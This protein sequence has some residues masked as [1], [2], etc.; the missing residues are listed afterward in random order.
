MLPFGNQSVTCIHR[1][2]KTDE[3][4]RTY[5][6]YQNYILTG[7]SYRKTETTDRDSDTRLKRERIIVRIPSGQFQP[8]IG[9]LLIKGSYLDV[10]DDSK[11]FSTLA[12][13]E[14][15]FLVANV[16]ENLTAPVIPHIACFSE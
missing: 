6:I 15:A 9:D 3:N 7:C 11:A 4:G 10:P 2:K 5:I 1:F 8:S 14:N 12:E 13:G 16:H